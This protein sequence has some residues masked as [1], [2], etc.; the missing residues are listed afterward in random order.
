MAVTK[1]TVE[2]PATLGYFSDRPFREDR[3]V[4]VKTTPDDDSN[5]PIS[6]G[7]NPIED[8]GERVEQLI[9]TQFDFPNNAEFEENSERMEQMRAAGVRPAE[10]VPDIVRAGMNLRITVEIIDDER[11]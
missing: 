5:V 7:E 3:V 10:G 4:H 2:G 9:A 8:L 6:V 1:F 11:I